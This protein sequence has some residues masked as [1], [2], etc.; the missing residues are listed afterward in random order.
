VVYSGH[1]SDARTHADVV[2]RVFLP[3]LIQHVKQAVEVQ[4][5]LEVTKSALQA[6]KTSSEKNLWTGISISIK[7]SH[8]MEKWVEALLREMVANL[9]T[10]M[11]A[12]C[13]LWMTFGSLLSKHSLTR[14]VVV[15]MECTIVRDELA[16]V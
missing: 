10:D 16:D 8:A 13:I 1:R 15:T 3:V 11:Q 6:F 14:Y 5:G 4:S 7:D 9:E 2:A 12:Y